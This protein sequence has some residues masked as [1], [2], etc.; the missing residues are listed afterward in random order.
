MSSNNL[1]EITVIVVGISGIEVIY[2]ALRTATVWKR[3]RIMALAGPM[4]KYISI[5][6]HGYQVNV[7]AVCCYAAFPCALS[8]RHY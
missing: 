5:L 7:I 3:P 4:S 6:R 8:R 2:V 1:F